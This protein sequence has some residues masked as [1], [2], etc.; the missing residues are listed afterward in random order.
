MNNPITLKSI[1]AEDK[2][3]L[4]GSLKNFR[5]P[6]DAKKLLETVDSYLSNL[7]A[8]EGKF[9][10]NLTESEEY[11]LLT[12][13]QILKAQQDIAFEISQSLAKGN[14]N[15]V[16]GNSPT[17]HGQEKQRNPFLAIIGTA[18]G[19]TIG[20]LAGTW[21]AAIG[22][23]VG[24]TLTIYLMTRNSSESAG[25]DNDTGEKMNEK[26]FVDII[27]KMCESIDN[28]METYRVQVM[29]VRNSYERRAKPNLLN[30]Y[31]ALTD[32]VANVCKIAHSLSDTVPNKLLQAVTMMEESLEN[33][34]LKYENGTIT[35]TDH[36][37]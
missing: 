31:S 15:P 26:V 22:A 6:Q 5:L 3:K 35:P 27:E 2:E 14:P 7:L 11:I 36:I 25:S 21:G 20:G 32:Q 28:V 37:K 33:Y 12:T 24:T 10:Q 8:S 29:R 4:A 23:I 16:N 9:R 1:F 17:R 13:I 18:V 34:D 30:E 19:G